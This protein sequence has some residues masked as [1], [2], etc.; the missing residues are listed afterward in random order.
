MKLHSTASLF[1]GF[2]RIETIEIP[3]PDFNDVYILP[4]ASLFWRSLP[5]IGDQQEQYPI[6]HGKN[7][8]CNNENFGNNNSTDD[9]H[10][11]CFHEENRTI[12]SYVRLGIAGECF[13]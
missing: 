3:F 9:T 12:K 2:N 6:N 1:Y 4:R 7:L 13:V 10:S 5:S 11:Y 8:D